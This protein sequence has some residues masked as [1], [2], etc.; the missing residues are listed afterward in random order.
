MHKA[1]KRPRK[2]KRKPKAP[3]APEYPTS[4][5]LLNFLCVETKELEASMPSWLKAKVAVQESEGARKSKELR[6]ELIQKQ[7]DRLRKI[8][9][10]EMRA[11]REGPRAKRLKVEKSGGEPRDPRGQFDEDKV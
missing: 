5:S 4:L 1:P 2:A 6:L 10:E 11:E 7:R 3:H 9:E 8:K